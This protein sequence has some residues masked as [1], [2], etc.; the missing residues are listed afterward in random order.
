V[1]DDLYTSVRWAHDPERQAAHDKWRAA[2]EAKEEAAKDA[3]DPRRAEERR[4]RATLLDLT[5][6][7]FPLYPIE[8]R[9]IESDRVISGAVG[10]RTYFRFCVSLEASPREFPSDAFDW[11]VGAVVYVV[12]PGGGT[13]AGTR[14]S[15]PTRRAPHGCGCEQRAR[16]FLAGAA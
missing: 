9:C 2:E 13:P 12:V 11:F 7:A 15:T 1:S 4:L 16:H 8:D 14:A 3:A 6:K 5:R 10:S